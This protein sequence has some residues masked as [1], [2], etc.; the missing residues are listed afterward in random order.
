METRSES[1]PRPASDGL[2]AEIIDK[3]TDSCDYWALRADG[4]FYF[5]RNLEEETEY[6]LTDDRVARVT[7]LLFYCKR[8]YGLLGT[9]SKTNVLISVS[10]GGLAGR[11]AL[12]VTWS[13]SLRPVSTQSAA[14]R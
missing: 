12:I 3:A 7:E 1:R 14:I 9:D 5:V 4:S 2:S 11:A 10:F 8:L 6:L 13:L